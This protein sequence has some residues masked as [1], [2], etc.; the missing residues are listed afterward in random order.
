MSLFVLNVII[1]DRTILCFP[2][3][4][5][6]WLFRSWMMFRSYMCWDVCHTEPFS[7]VIFILEMSI[8]VWFVSNNLYYHKKIKFGKNF[9]EWQIFVVWQVENDRFVSTVSHRHLF[10]TTR[11]SAGNMRPQYSPK[12]TRVFLLVIGKYT[13][14]W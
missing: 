14:F 13:F 4:I 3:W 9:G 8:R 5:M 2:S 10:T 1:V 11:F 12:E 7:E 6:F